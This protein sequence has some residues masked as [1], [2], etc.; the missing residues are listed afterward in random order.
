MPHLA[1]FPFNCAPWF[2]RAIVFGRGRDARVSQTQV[3]LGSCVPQNAFAESNH[4]KPERST[5]LSRDEA[6]GSFLQPPSTLPHAHPFRHAGKCSPLFS[7][8]RFAD[9]EVPL[10]G[11]VVNCTGAPTTPPLS[12]HRASA[13]RLARFGAAARSLTR[14][15]G[16]RP[17]AVPEL[18]SPSLMSSAWVCPTARGRLRFHT[19]RTVGAS[20]AV[21][22]C[23]AHRDPSNASTAQ[24]DSG[25]A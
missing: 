12:S 18:F 13:T 11:A 14:R 6:E 1:V 20:G 7:S 5:P 21:Y 4:S 17:V 9:C 8:R 3:S 23:A 19:R 16:S 22:A 25:N 10:P 15:G 2:A 24:D